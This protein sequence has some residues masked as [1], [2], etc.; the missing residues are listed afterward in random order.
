MVSSLLCFE[1]GYGD[2][3]TGHES[4]SLNVMRS[5]RLLHAFNWVQCGIEMIN[6]NALFRIYSYTSEK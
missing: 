2:D 5:G 4:N 6:R 3:E 1:D